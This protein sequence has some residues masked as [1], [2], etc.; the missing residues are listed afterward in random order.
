M[1]IRTI[2]AGLLISACL[3]ALAVAQTAPPPSPHQME[4]AKRVIDDVGG[5]KM[6]D[7]VMNAMMGSMTAQMAGG[8][9]KDAQE[10]TRTI[11]M[12]A[13]QATMARVMPKMMDVMTVSYAQTFSEQE[14]TDIDTFYRSPSGQAM[15]NKLPQ[16][17]ASTMQAMGPIQLEMRQDFAQEYCQR[18]AC[19]P[20]MRAAMEGRAP[21]GAAPTHP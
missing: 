5:E 6:I 21:P 16:M 17:M 14:L 3:P 15:I 19:T 18:T 13:L 10:K 20:A 7:Q 2:A 9:S 12:P 1:R 11:L 8:Q 4:L